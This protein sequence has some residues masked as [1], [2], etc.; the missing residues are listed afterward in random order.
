MV[1]YLL[2]I[3]KPKYSNCHVLSNLEDGQGSQEPCPND[4][5]RWFLIHSQFMSYI[6]LLILLAIN[7]CPF[8]LPA[9]L[10]RLVHGI[11]KKHSSHEPARS[12]FC[13]ADFFAVCSQ[14]K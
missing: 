10:V 4:K 7:I 2:A 12:V 5:F 13:N 11:F 9:E 1:G 3:L 14:K 6:T 8:A